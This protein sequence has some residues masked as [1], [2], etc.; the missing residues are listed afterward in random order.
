MKRIFTDMVHRRARRTEC[1]PGLNH[2]ELRKNTH[3][4][5]AL[6]D[7]ESCAQ[8]GN[9]IAFSCRLPALTQATCHANRLPN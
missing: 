9:L 5:G 6:P 4:H 1:D 8:V 3:T 7:M 2:A